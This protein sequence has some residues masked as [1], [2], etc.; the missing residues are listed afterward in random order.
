MVDSVIKQRKPSQ[1]YKD[2]DLSFAKFEYEW[3]RCKT[4]VAAKR[5]KVLI[6][7]QYYESYFPS[8]GLGWLNCYWTADITT[9]SL[10]ASEIKQVI[11]NYEKE[12]FELKELYQTHNQTQIVLLWYLFMFLEY[13]EDRNLILYWRGYDNESAF[14]TL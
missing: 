12:G 2:F 8:L 10:I 11:D 4:D 5:L 14:F 13:K 9:A 1:I 7:T 3:Y 6:R